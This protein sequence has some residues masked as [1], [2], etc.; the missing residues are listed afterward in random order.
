MKHCEYCHEMLESD[1]SFC[2]NCGAPIEKPA[3]PVIAAPTAQTAAPKTDGFSVAALILGILSVFCCCFGA[4]F[5]ILAIVFGAIALSRIAKTKNS[6][7][8][9]AV[10]AIVLGSIMLVLTLAGILASAVTGEIT[11]DFDLDLPE[12]FAAPYTI[13]DVPFAPPEFD[14]FNPNIGEV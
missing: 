11:Y 13:P 12:S 2:P 14:A 10:V 8:E 9:M 7:K 3:E 5:S 4:L 1:M 6:G